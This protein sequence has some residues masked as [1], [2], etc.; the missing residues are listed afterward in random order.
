MA[1]KPNMIDRRNKALGGQSNDRAR[2][3]IKV[4]VWH[5]TATNEGSIE[6]HENYWK[7]NNGWDRG[8]YHFYIDRKGVIYQNYNV[9][10]MTWGVA[11]NNGHTVHIS[12]EA[13][14]KKDYTDTQIKAREQVTRWLMADLNISASNVKGHWEVYNNTSCPGYTKA[15]MDKFRSGLAKATSNANKPASNPVS[16]TVDQLAQ[17]V[18]K[19]LHGTGEVRQK[20]LGSQYAAVQARVNQILAPNA[21]SAPKPKPQK[22]V[23]QLAREVIDGKHGN[24]DARKKSLGSQYTPVQKRVDEILAPKPKLKPNDTIAREVVQG[25]WGNGPDR[26]ARLEKAGYNYTTI[27]NLVNRMF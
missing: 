1:T 9:E 24:G 17:E 8:G 22:T 21:K 19:G 12:L 10:R 13:A 2:S 23:E 27:Q 6:S 5:Y 11:N 25:L 16:K 26:K 20:R 7:N 4:I 14:S 15:E 18:I 3:A